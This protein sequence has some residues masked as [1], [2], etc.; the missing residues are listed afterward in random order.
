MLEVDVINQ[1]YLQKI[2]ID[3]PLLPDRVNIDKCQ[4]FMCNIYDKESY[5]VHKKSPRAGLGLGF[6][7]RKGS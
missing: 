6:N 4:K 1:K 5:V 2:H 3:L 7:F